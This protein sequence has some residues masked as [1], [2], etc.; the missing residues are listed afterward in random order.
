MDGWITAWRQKNSQRR[1]RLWLWFLVAVV[2]LLTGTGWGVYSFALKKVT[3]Q[4]DNQGEVRVSTFARDVA[5]L[6][7]EK[8]IDL[9]PEDRVEPS[10]ATPLRSGMKV[11]VS[12]AVPVTVRVDGREITVKV[13]LPVK[14]REALAVA[15]VAVG[16]DDRVEP[17]LDT[18]LEAGTEIKVTRVTTKEVSVEQELPYRV[19]RREDPELEKGISRTIQKGRK[20]LALQIYRVIYEDGQE[21]KREFVEEKILKEPVPEIVA[22]GILT[23]ASRGGQTFHFERSFWAIVTA[24][25]EPNGITATGTRP[26]VG[27]IAVDPAVVPLGSRLYVEGYGFGVAQDV[28]SAIKGNRIDVY[29]ESEEAAWRWGVKRVKVYVLD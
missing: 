9:Q 5:A 7:A 26:K 20:G 29:L 10:L 17:A 16:P 24:Y 4:V 25:Y 23:T 3:L 13:V 2:L 28:G 1:R 15:G 11:V 12:H 21:V 19:V 14:V 6:L 18:V 8:A 22:A 27:T